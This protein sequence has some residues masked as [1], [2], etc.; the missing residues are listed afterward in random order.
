MSLEFHFRL[1]LIF[2]Q[3]QKTLVSLS[4]EG[5]RP[6]LFYNCPHPKGCHYS[7]AVV[8]WTTPTGKDT[9]KE[10]MGNIRTVIWAV[11][12]KT[13]DERQ[14]EGPRGG[15]ARQESQ[16]KG[17]WAEQEDGKIKASLGYLSRPCLKA[18]KPNQMHQQQTSASASTSRVPWTHLSI[19]L[20]T[21]LSKYLGAGKMAQWLRALAALPKDLAS[22]FSSHIVAYS[23]M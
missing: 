6:I 4:K 17:R 15:G 10:K 2:F 19:Y 8:I 5:K 12:A 13:T 22:I 3:P 16:P 23:H 14:P 18:R 9:Q 1:L 20:S 21:Y 7:D 11:W